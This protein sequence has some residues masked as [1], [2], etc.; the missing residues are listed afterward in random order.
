MASLFDKVMWKKYFHWFLL[1]NFYFLLTNIVIIKVYAMC[2]LG[3]QN[4]PVFFM[5]LLPSG[6]SITAMCALMGKLV[7]EGNVNV[8]RDFFRF[9]VSNI[10]EALRLWIP[11]LIMLFGIIWIRDQVE[12]G[13]LR[14]LLTLAIL[15]C[16]GFLGLMF[17]ILS[18]FGLRIKDILRITLL[19]VIIKINLAIG[20]FAIFL[21]AYLMLTQLSYYFVLIIPSVAFYLL[22]FILKNMLAEIEDQLFNK[23]N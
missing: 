20:G 9:Y 16:F 21:A 13:F 2:E 5:A 14:M 12:E 17:P 18:R 8:T 1:A 10:K 11:F 7:R 4:L 3:F 23:T 15:A 6:L 19:Y 22:L